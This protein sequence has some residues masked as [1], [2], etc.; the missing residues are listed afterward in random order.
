MTIEDMKTKI[1]RPT[2]TSLNAKANAAPQASTPSTETDG[3]RG[4]AHRA[5]ESGAM[6]YHAPSAYRQA[7]TTQVPPPSSFFGGV[8]SLRIPKPSEMFGLSHGIMRTPAH[9][10]VQPVPPSTVLP[11]VPQLPSQGQLSAASVTRQREHDRRLRAV[12]VKMQRANLKRRMAATLNGGDGTDPVNL[13]PSDMWSTHAF[14]SRSSRPNPSTTSLLGGVFTGLRH[15]ATEHIQGVSTVSPEMD[16]GVHM[17]FDT[18]I[19]DALVYTVGRWLGLD[20]EQL[21]DSPGLRT[22]VSRNIQWFRASPDWMKLLGLVMA[23]KLNHSLDCPR[24]VTSYSDTQRMLLDRLIRDDAVTKSAETQVSADTE[25]PPATEADEVTTAPP[26]PPLK[27]QKRSPKTAP[28]PSKAKKTKAVSKDGTK[29][30]KAVTFSVKR[31]KDTDKRMARADRK[32]RTSTTTAPID[33]SSA[34]PL[35]EGV[36]FDITPTVPTTEAASDPSVTD[37]LPSGPTSRIPIEETQLA[38]TP[39]FSFATGPTALSP[40]R[41][42]ASE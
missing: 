7:G 2:R 21:R 41:E 17:E 5:L 9:A 42:W 18:D 37:S 31:M 20:T 16:A 40:S 8:T 19:V 26:T 29:K 30:K 1:L 36:F 11:T 4:Q 10:A 13:D 15:W 23:K 22:L 38:T 25:M 6:A 28:S 34:A 33:P 14:H 12:S 35:P 39:V 3:S 27:R 24:R 32:R